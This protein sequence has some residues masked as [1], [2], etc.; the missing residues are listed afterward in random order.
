MNKMIVSNLVHRPVRSL[1]SISAIAL[2]VTL[3]LLIVS[4]FYG[5]LNGSKESQVGVAG[6]R[7]DGAASGIKSAPSLELRARPCP[8]EGGRCAS[9][10]KL[11]HVNVAAPV[12]WELTTKPTLEIIYGPTDRATTLQQHFVR[13]AVISKACPFQGRL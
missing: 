3:I 5:Q 8:G 6:C 1:I 4:F 9:L 12:I 11:P 2:E 10:R 7:C 13:V